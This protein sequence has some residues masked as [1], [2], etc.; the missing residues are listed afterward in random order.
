MGALDK[1][2]AFRFINIAMKEYF[3]HNGSNYT[4]ED[5]DSWFDRKDTCGAERLDK[6]TIVEYLQS[7]AL[8][9]KVSNKQVPKLVSK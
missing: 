4:S 3:G 7:Q 2:E 8:K 5:F 1:I 6:A 9:K